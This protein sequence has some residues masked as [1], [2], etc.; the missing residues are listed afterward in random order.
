MHAD[1]LSWLRRELAPFTGRADATLRLV[2]ASAIIITVS[3]TL[4]VPLIAISLIVAFM[5][6]QQNVVLSKLSAI[7]VLIGSLLAIGITILLLKFTMEYPLLRLLSTG[8]ILVVS[9]YGMRVFKLGALFFQ[10]ALVVVYGQ[11]LADQILEPEQLVRV[12]LWAWVAINYATVV[13]LMINFLVRPADPVRQ[14][15]ALLREQLDSAEALL[16]CLLSTPHTAPLTPAPP[17]LAADLLKF[18][19]LQDARIKA[20]WPR[21]QALLTLAERLQAAAVLWQCDGPLP[22]GSPAQASAI[23][24]RQTIRQLAA[25]IGQQSPSSWLA[26]LPVVAETGQLPPALAEMAAAL[27][28]YHE[29]ALHPE[30]LPAPSK[31]RLIV[32]DAFNNP[33]YLQFACKTLL[34]TLLG[35]LFYQAVQ[36]PGIHT[37]M[38]TCV[39]IALPSL[40]AIAQKGVL[41]IGGVLLGSLLALLATVFFIPHLE[42]IVGLL[43]ITLPVIALSGWIA[44]GSERISY[45]GVQIMFA[46]ALALLEQFSPVTELTEIRD[47]LMGVI[48]GVVLTLLIQA[49]I[50][51]ESEARSLRRQL[52]R[53][54]R[55]YAAMM[56]PGSPE[57][58][59]ALTSDVGRQFHHLEETLARMRL[60]PG[61]QAPETAGL[62]LA[63]RDTLA[64]SRRVIA[65]ISQWQALSAGDHPA[66]TSLLRQAMRQFERALAQRLLAQAALIEQEDVLEQPTENGLAAL[67]RA[68]EHA[69]QQ[70]SPDNASALMHL[71]EAAVELHACILQITRWQLDP[72]PDARIVTTT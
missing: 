26:P 11:S 10:I 8:V 14:L 60:E 55:Q 1:M 2:I 32:A 28:H 66:A 13:A 49:W 72:S 45:A 34:A 59:Q 40:G 37:V 62:Q 3:M 36:W 50:A 6:T 16:A 33:V 54:L 17:V 42:S 48:L 41:R 9:F 21:Y 23:A 38:L 70:A 51:P 53:M 61:W 24:L 18:C 35:Y 47:R 15:R 30:R 31:D 4:Q 67:R 22:P 65:A 25:Q 27:Q 68:C 63:G 52:A 69:M 46:F 56:R 43:V 20:E 19:A 58:E 64:V 44:A 29:G 12:C 39:I 5:V 7:I 57:A 71:L